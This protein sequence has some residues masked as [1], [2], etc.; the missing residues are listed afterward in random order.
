MT[1]RYYAPE[2]PAA[3]GPVELDDQEAGHAVRVMRAQLG[4]ELTL[5]DGQGQQ[6]EATIV[7][8]DRRHCTVRAQA[9]KVVDRDPSRRLHLAVALPRPERAKEMVERLTELGVAQLTPLVCERTQRPPSPALLGK[10]RRVVVEACKQCGRNRLMH[11]ADPVS[12][13][14]F[15][16]AKTHGPWWIAHPTGSLPVAAGIGE[17]T[18]VGVLIGPEGGFTE[19]EREQARQSGCQSLGLGKRIYRIETAATVVAALLAD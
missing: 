14:D 11:V 15:L 17:A 8:I 10:L 13:T 18:G 2:L 12:L 9:P 5:F 1:R 19:Q 3:G 7:A 4:D 16:A 6:A